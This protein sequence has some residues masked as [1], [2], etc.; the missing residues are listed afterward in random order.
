MPHI[1]L[2]ERLPG[3]TAGFAFRPET[4]KPMR[5]LAHILLHES[6]NLAPGEQRA[7]SHICFIA[8]RLL[9]LPDEP[10]RR[11]GCSFRR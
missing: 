1:A 4:A 2:P 11:S 10:W 3:I 5:E 9:F 6:N 7:D 8:K